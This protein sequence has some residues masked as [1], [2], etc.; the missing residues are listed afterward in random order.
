MT[1]VLAGY[2]QEYLRLRRQMGATLHAHEGLITN[3]L[4]SLETAGQ[5]AI[6]VEAAVAWAVLPTDASPR[7]R[8]YRLAVVRGFAA[9]VHA[10]NP[11]L[12]PIIAAGLIPSKVVH[13]IPYIYTPRQTVE[14]MDAALSLG[15]P[16][17]GLTVSTVIGLMAA[18]GMR[19]G[20][21]LALNLE[22][23]DLAA[24]VIT[25]TGKYGKERL[26]PLH[27]STAGALG[28]YLSASRDLVTAR[29]PDAFFL[30]YIGTRPHTGNLQTA[31]RS[32]ATPLGLTPRPGAKAP[33]LH[34]FRHT[35]ATE[36]LTEAYHDGADA[37]ARIAVLATYL[38]HVSPASTYWYL[39]STPELLALVTE[40]VQTAQTHGKLLS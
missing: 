9:Y 4:L 35:F 17:R 36:S 14:L 24:D 32:L 13:A 6:T 3:F 30:T 38:G 34:D 8:A 26:V 20:E 10:R 33:R 27:P 19:I 25:V 16:A 31:F 5:G 2:E 22:D 18:T 11:A 37:D 29:D 15:P 28:R 7:W 39:S 40:R 23:V 21:A 1:T 12:A